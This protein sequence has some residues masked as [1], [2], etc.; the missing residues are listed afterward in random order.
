[1]TRT[2]L[3]PRPFSCHEPRNAEF[4]PTISGKV[5]RVSHSKRNAW[6]AEVIIN[7]ATMWMAHYATKAAAVSACEPMIETYT[8]IHYVSR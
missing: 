6:R 5:S 4:Q 7:D 3:W 2:A 1:M 8:A